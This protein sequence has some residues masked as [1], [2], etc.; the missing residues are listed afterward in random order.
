MGN[1]KRIIKV[2]QR[3]SQLLQ[4][5][6]MSIDYKKFD[7][8]FPKNTYEKEKLDTMLNVPMEW[9]SKFDE[10][11]QNSG[12]SEY[13]DHRLVDKMTDRERELFVVVRS[14]GNKQITFLLDA[15]SKLLQ[16]EDG[17]KE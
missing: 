7:K 3:V 14:I 8:I 15:I 4:G 2:K 17:Q 5:R 1:T 9:I 16:K 13:K 6:G 12:F 10:E 11:M